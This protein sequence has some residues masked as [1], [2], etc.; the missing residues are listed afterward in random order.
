[1]A[2]TRGL[3]IDIYY[4]PADLSMDGRLVEDKYLAILTLVKKSV[5]IPVAVK[6][7]PYFSSMANMA[8]RLDETGADAL[9]LFNRFYETDFDI[10]NMTMSHK[11]QL[12]GPG[13]IRLPLQ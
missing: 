10:E 5:S 6:L 3:E 2:G 4:I 11:L 7:N 12:S 9:V 13:E 1:A 8:K